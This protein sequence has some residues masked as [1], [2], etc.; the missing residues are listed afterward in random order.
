MAEF[1]AAVLTVSDGVAHGAR[2]DTSGEVLAWML[3]DLVDKWW[4]LA[5]SIAIV[6]AVLWLEFKDWRGKDRSA[7]GCG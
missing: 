6:I 1:R 4:L 3:A 2:E 7:M 5:I